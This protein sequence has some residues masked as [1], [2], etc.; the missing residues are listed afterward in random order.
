MLWHPELCVSQL[1]LVAGAGTWTAVGAGQW[2]YGRSELVHFGGQT[3]KVHGSGFKRFFD[4]A[5]RILL[6]GLSF[7]LAGSF[8]TCCAGPAD[9]CKWQIT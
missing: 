5:I 8:L 6:K 1:S 2:G 9:F 3:G 4:L 7:N